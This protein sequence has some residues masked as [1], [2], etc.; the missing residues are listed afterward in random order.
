MSHSTTASYSN[1][2]VRLKY[3]H[4]SLI[5]FDPFSK[6]NT[7]NTSP[8]QNK[9]CGLDFGTSNSSIGYL[10]DAEPTLARFGSK[11]YIPSAVFYDF[12]SDHPIFGNEAIDRYVDGREGRMLWSPKNALG[13][14]LIA[15]K[16]R[17]RYGSVSFKDIIAALVMN[18]KT[19]CEAQAQCELTSVVAGRPVFFNDDD[20]ELDRL[21]QDSMQQILQ[22][23]GFKNIAFE[24]EPIA[25]A[26]HYEQLIENE[27]IAFV[28][29]M[30]G[31]TSD[32]TVAKLT[33]HS[34][35]R[36][37]NILSVGGIHVAGTDF[38]RQLSLKTLMPE[39][40]FGSRYK[41]LEGPWLPVPPS[42]F[43]DLATW[44]KIGFVYTQQ[45]INF[46][47]S[48]IF[49]SECPQNFERLLYTLKY[50]FGHYLARLVE[51]SKIEL[52]DN[53]VAVLKTTDV[54]P[55]LDIQMTRADFEDSIETHISQIATTISDTIAKAGVPPSRIDAIFMTGGSSLI[56]SVRRSIQAIMPDAQVFEG[57]KFGSVA[58][59]LTLAARE[60]FA[61]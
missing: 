50:R 18:L 10:L 48:K 26:I 27:Q 31:G 55:A 49:T 16:T 53:E 24:Y 22:Q 11:T 15:E 13:T 60:R 17:V 51:K 19:Q 61:S 38:D 58:F 54:K 39:L 41:S 59:G 52:S 36:T 4:E 20:P 34:R 30:G 43:F 44:H 12:D 33:P 32:F 47:K 56:P 42:L 45:N 8:S 1:E 3:A 37:K 2:S 28:V 6:T 9:S 57:D 5:V 14:G 25:A 21:A 35:D 46:V 23:V 29:D 7:M 40:G